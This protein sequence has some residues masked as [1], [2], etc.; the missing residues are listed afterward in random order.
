MRI[1]YYAITFADCADCATSVA[2]FVASVAFDCAT[3]VAFVSVAFV[4][5]VATSVLRDLR[6]RV[7]RDANKPLHSFQRCVLFVLIH[8]EWTEMPR[9][10][11][12]VQLGSHNV[13][14][15]ALRGGRAVLPRSVRR[16]GSNPHPLARSSHRIRVARRESGESV[17]KRNGNGVV[18]G[19]R[20]VDYAHRWSIG[21]TTLDSLVEQ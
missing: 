18:I 11:L 2:T 15:T 13:L 1:V 17:V 12:E 14:V 6:T 10:G 9:P 5:F 20:K 3:F 7:L 8:G 21:R 16:A 19:V 4:A